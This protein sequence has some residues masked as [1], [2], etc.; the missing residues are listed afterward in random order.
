MTEVYEHNPGDHD[1]PVAGSTWLIGA[2]GTAAL[3][4][5]IFGVTALLY[6]ADEEQMLVSVVNQPAAEQQ[7]LRA[8]QEARLAKEP[9][10][11]KVREEGAETETD[12]FVIPIER[13]MELVVREA[14]E[15]RR[16]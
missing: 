3:L 9:Q 12:A 16:R 14:G 11:I 4:V 6:H 15:S 10:W 2:V 5:T 8:E 1:D 7:R 13:A